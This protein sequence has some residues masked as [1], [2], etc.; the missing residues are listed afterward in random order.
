MASASSSSPS[1]KQEHPTEDKDSIVT[2]KQQHPTGEDE[3]SFIHVKVVNQL[4]RAIV[5]RVNRDKPLRKLLAIWR[6]LEGITDYHKVCF[7]F[8]GP[9]IHDV[10]TANDI[11]LKDGDCIY[12]LP[13][14]IGD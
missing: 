14:M 10:K 2:V 7:M 12:A 5:F 3:D 8:N 11:G 4:N 1:V 13:S 6:E 9:R